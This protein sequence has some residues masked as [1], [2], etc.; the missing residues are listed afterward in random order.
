MTAV[1]IASALGGKRSGRSWMAKCPAHGERTPS[2]SIREANG[3]VLIHC[4]GGCSQTAVIDALRSRG[5]WQEAPRQD[6]TP[7]Q[8]RAWA[9]ARRRDAEDGPLAAAWGRAAEC[10]ALAALEQLEPWSLERMNLTSLLKTVRAGGPG[11]VLEYCGWR[12]REPSLTPALVAA[13]R[14]LERR[15][16][17]S[18]ARLCG[19]RS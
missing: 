5:L 10:L 19:V 4:F 11:L 16:A 17:A 18:L 2:L 3:K 6:W 9:E 8:R 15:H 14:S 1:D 12:E 13:G 7:E